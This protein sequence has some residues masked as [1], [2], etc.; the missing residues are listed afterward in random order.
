[1]DRYSVGVASK[2]VPKVFHKLKFLRWAEVE[3]RIHFAF[4]AANQDGLRGLGA[5][6]RGP[7]GFQK[8]RQ[9]PLSFL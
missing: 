4:F 6:R 2:V 8:P 7:D 1:M 5:A 3:D 9:S